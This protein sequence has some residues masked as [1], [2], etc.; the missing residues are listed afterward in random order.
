MT[1]DGGFDEFAKNVKLLPH[2]STSVIIRSYFG[3]FGMPHPLFV[4]TN[5]NL[6]TSMIERMDS[7]LRAFAAGELTN[8]SELV[9][10]RYVVP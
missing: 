6:S 5:G 7:F 8:Y 4:S 2:D 10:K 3:R 9:F 1:R